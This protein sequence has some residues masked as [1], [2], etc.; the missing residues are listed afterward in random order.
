VGEKALR[1][2]EEGEQWDGSDKTVV[3]QV[4]VSFI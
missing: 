2:S 4:D 1:W 3:F